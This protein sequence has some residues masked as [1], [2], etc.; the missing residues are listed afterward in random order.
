VAYDDK[1]LAVLAKNE[2]SLEARGCLEAVDISIVLKAFDPSIAT[3]PSQHLI[4]R[5][6]PDMA[7]YGVGLGAQVD[8]LK[9][10]SV[11]DSH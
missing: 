1:E 4:S 11:F 9:V 2:A 7:R 10:R 6:T 3:E 5:P 8:D